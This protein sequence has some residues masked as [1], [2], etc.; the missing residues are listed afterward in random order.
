MRDVNVGLFRNRGFALLWIGG[1]I[2]MTGDWALR[3][4]VPIAVYRMTGSPAATSAVVATVVAVSL[5]VSPLAGVFVV[6]WDL[7]STLFVANAAHALILLP[8]RLVNRA[9]DPKSWGALLAR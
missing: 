2:S 3:V 1:L 7:C 4:A 9:A 6:R 8:M 5:L